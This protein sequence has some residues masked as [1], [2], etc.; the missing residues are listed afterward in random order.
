MQT[1]R[2]R[3]VGNVRR[4]SRSDQRDRQGWDARTRWA[5]APQGQSPALGAPDAVPRSGTALIY[6]RLNSAMQRGL[7]WASGSQPCLEAP[8]RRPQ[9]GIRQEPNSYNWCSDLQFLGC[10]SQEIDHCQL[11]RCRGSE[12]APTTGPVA[13]TGNDAQKS[14][15]SPASG[16]AVDSQRQSPQVEA[17]SGDTRRRRNTQ[18]IWSASRRPGE[19]VP[20]APRIFSNI[21]PP[22]GAAAY[23]NAWLLGIIGQ[24]GARGTRGVAEP[25]ERGECRL[26]RTAGAASVMHADASHARPGATQ[27]EGRKPISR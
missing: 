6:K 18:E 13:K 23:S 27:T 15:R 11:R 21:C 3:G 24:H 4:V 26:V 25:L 8:A 2:P 12:P 19:G 10:G 7:G 22:C 17:S 5:G 16:D 9:Q 1:R 20:L 14:Q